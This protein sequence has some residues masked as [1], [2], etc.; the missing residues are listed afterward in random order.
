MAE[1]EYI[2]FV[3]LK[4][5]VFSNKVSKKGD[6]LKHNNAKRENTRDMHQRQHELTT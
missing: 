1:G 4:A 6:Q 3:L 2:V 5:G